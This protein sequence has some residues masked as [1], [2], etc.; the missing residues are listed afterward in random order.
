MVKRVVD[1]A[2]WTDMQVIDNYSV[3]DKYF[4][5][6]LMTNN[7][8]TQVGIYPLPKKVIGFETGFSTEVIQVLLERFAE[9]Y[10]KIKYSEKTQEVTVLHSLQ[11]TILKG[12]KPVS[13][14]L[15]KELARVKDSEL[16]LATYEEMKSFW[17]LSKRAFDK[18]IQVLFEKELSIRGLFISQNINE[19]ESQNQ[20][21]NINENEIGNDNE[22]HNHNDNEESGATN[23]LANRPANRNEE[24]CQLIERYAN[25]LKQCKPEYVGDIHA[26]NIVTVFYQQM[27][28]NILPHVDAQLNH[29]QKTLPKSLVL[30]AIQRS[31]NATHPILYMGKVIDNWEK[32]NVENMKDVIKLDRESNP[33]REG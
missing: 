24:E 12:G 11:S 17:E 4:S 13:D 21:E 9:R 26:D 29:W 30:E 22:N 20:N 25:Y 27:I 28:G 5:L 16:I 23:R 2:F 19:N 32:A 33:M 18:T 1:T 15:E 10:G 7:Q 3:E 8:T 31:V 6:Y 14:L